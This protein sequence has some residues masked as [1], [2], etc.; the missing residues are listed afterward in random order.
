MSG[1]EFPCPSCESKNLHSEGFRSPGFC[2]VC[3][4]CQM[5]GPRAG[6]NKSQEIGI[7]K[8]WEAWANL[9][10]RTPDASGTNNIEKEEKPIPGSW[11]IEHRE[12]EPDFISGPFTNGI[13]VVSASSTKGAGP[14]HP[15]QTILNTIIGT[16]QGAAEGYRTFTKRSNRDPHLV[17]YK[18][19]E[20]MAEK[21][22]AIWKKIRPALEAEGSG[23]VAGNISKAKFRECTCVDACKGKEGL[24]PGWKCAMDGGDK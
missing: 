15:L 19:I 21:A 23:E 18:E 10:R 7:K 17:T 1:N 12:G 4:D 2:I 3:E 6:K 8:A 9:P 13:E 24:A 5:R 14:D 22:L 11:W 16:A 20:D